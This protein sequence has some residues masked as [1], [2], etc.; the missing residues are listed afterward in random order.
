MVLGSSSP[1]RVAPVV[2]IMVVTDYHQLSGDRIG[3]IFWIARM[4]Q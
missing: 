3:M 4:G 2:D 1:V